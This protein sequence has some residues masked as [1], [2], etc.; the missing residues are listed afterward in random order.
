[1]EEENAEPLPPPPPAPAPADPA[2]LPL[3]V[4]AETVSLLPPT[5]PPDTKLLPPERKVLPLLML[6]PLPPVF[7]SR[8]RRASSTLRACRLAASPAPFRLLS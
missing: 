6:P 2:P 1:M 7:C 8:A 4:V 3:P 5:L